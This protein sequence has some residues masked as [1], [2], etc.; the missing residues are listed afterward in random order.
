MT[1]IIRG[2]AAAPGVAVGPVF[3]VEMEKASEEGHEPAG[4]PSEEGDRLYAALEKA[5][6]QLD[7]LARQVE[8]KIGPEESGIFLAQAAFASDPTLIQ[9]AEEA[10]AGGLS[11]ETG[12]TQAFQTFRQQLEASSSERLAARVTDLD[13]VRDRVIGIL[14]GRPIGAT[15][16]NVPSVVVAAELTP[17]ETAGLPARMVLAIATERGTET[18][19]AAILA[20]GLGVPSVVG[21]EGLLTAARTAAE[22]A[23]DGTHGEVFV[24]PDPETR[25]RLEEAAVDREKRRRELAGL[26]WVPGATRD[27]RHVEL[28]ANIGSLSELE[29]ASQA[30]AEGCGLVRTEFL[31]QDRTDRPSVDEQVVVYRQILSAFPDHRVVFRTLDIGADKPL[32]FIPRPLEANPALGVR[33]IRLGLHQPDLLNDQL[34]AITRACRESPGRG[35]VMF[36]MVT[37]TAEIDESLAMLVAVAEEEGFDMQRLEVGAMVE[38]PVAALIAGRLA[39]RLDFVSVGTNDLL[40]YLFAADRLQTELADLPDLF[41]PAVL[42]LLSEMV[43][44]AHAAKAWVGVCGEAAGTITGAAA[45]VGLGCDEL[46]MAPS[47]IPEV[48]DALRQVTAPDLEEAVDRAMRAEGPAEA[49]QIMDAALPERSAVPRKQ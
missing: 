43:T 27:G 31:F 41:E 13:D 48:K 10:I 32:P 38:T 42:R 8:T 3:I 35:A 29:S 4:S 25:R 12:V 47:A 36:P 49:R 46:S 16:P 21:A 5:A 2:V 40:Q 1:G 11:A 45:L 18:S 44:D 20:R 39:W 33:G 19:H 23:V 14:T 7:E 34:R 6:E 30:G 9:R 28:A 17:S 22:M 26:R 37:R 24:D 15:G